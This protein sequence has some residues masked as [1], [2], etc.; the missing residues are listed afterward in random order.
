[1]LRP[2]S[3]YMRRA[4]DGRRRTRHQPPARPCLRSPCA[5]HGGSLASRGHM[6]A[7]GLTPPLPPF[8]PSSPDW[9]RRPDFRPI[10]RIDLRTV[11]RNDVKNG[12]IGP[13]L[14]FGGTTE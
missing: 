12:D 3:R 5:G 10:P 1:M 7:L 8:S 9:A 2:G 13:R 14:K 6:P 11:P 4:R